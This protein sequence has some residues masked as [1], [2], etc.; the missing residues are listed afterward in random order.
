MPRTFYRIFMAAMAVLAVALALDT[1]FM[2][3]PSYGIIDLRDLPKGMKSMSPVAKFLNER[4]QGKNPLPEESTFAAVYKAQTRKDC[5]ADMR[6]ARTADGQYV[7]ELPL[8]KAYVI[9]YS[10]RDLAQ[11]GTGWSFVSEDNSGI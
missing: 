6:Y 4:L 10:S 9:R 2:R 3:N 11:Y 7:L 8:W 5:P 1:Y